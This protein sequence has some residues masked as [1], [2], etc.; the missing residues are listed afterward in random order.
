MIDEFV[1]WALNPKLSV[2][3]AY[4][5]ERMVEHGVSAWDSKRQIFDRKSFELRHDLHKR[6][7]LNPAH[8]ARLLPAEVEKAAEMLPTILRTDFDSYDDRPVRDLSGLRFLPQLESLHLSHTELHD[9]SPVAGLVNLKELSL[10]D[11]EIEDLRPLGRCTA[12]RKLHVRLRQPWPLLEGFENLEQLEEIQWHGNLLSLEVI[13][14]L[15]RVNTVKFENNYHFKLPLRDCRRLPEMPELRVL[16]LD[17]ICRLDGVERW[18]VL[19]NL[20]VGGPLRDLHPLQALKELT[21]LTVKSEDLRDVSPLIR[22]PELRRLLVVSEHPLDFSCLTEAPRL[23]E[24]EME[25]CDINKME[26]ATLNAVLARWDEEFALPAPRALPAPVFC[27]CDAK[28]FPNEKWDRAAIEAERDRD[29]GLFTSEAHWVARRMGADINKLLGGA[30]W[31]KVSA[32][33]HGRCGWLSITTLT[34]AERLAD[35]VAASRNVLAMTRQPWAVQFHVCL[36]NELEREDAPKELDEEEEVRQ[37]LEEMREYKQREK[38]KKDYL[39][40]LH[41]MQLKQQEGSEVKSEDFAPPEIPAPAAVKVVEEAKETEAVAGVEPAKTAPEN[42]LKLF[43]NGNED[44]PL[45]ED[46]YVWG[47]ITEGGVWVIERSVAAAEHLMG[48]KVDPA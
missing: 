48:R 22:L 30:K 40:R 15:L 28:D 4:C 46:L 5:A 44:H 8:R 21:H 43:G 26:L 2:E 17:P 23:R 1:E 13:P 14:R 41:R 7:K 11:D 38:E 25:R 33:G 18:T 12:L 31:G 47:L 29:P 34:G 35:I 27:V 37:E 24:V 3:E 39:E 42:V 20:T 10:F 9:L 36:D 45:A 19:R 6:R 16:E 32:E